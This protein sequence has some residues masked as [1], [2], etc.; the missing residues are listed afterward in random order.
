MYKRQNEFVTLKGKNIVD[1]LKRQG[2]TTLGTGAVGWF[3][4]ST[5]TAQTLTRDFDRFFFSGNCW[6]LDKQLNWID[7]QIRQL[8]G[9]KVFVFL[10]IVE[11]HVPY[12]YEGAPWDR[13]IN[14]CRPFGQDNDAAECRRRQALCLEWVDERLGPLLD[15][16][17]HA[18]TICCADHGDAWGEDGLWEHGVHHPKVL[19]VPLLYRLQH[20]PV[21]MAGAGAAARRGVRSIAKKV[22]DKIK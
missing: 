10:N 19:E 9:K 21:T 3:D 17:A 12:Y 16:F 18:N 1:G 14:P 5:V 4:D 2:F 8:D 7:E 15:R 20:A 6:S 11:T 22:R 13:Q